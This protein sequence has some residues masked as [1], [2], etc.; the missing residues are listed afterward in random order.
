MEKREEEINGEEEI[1]AHHVWPTIT[2]QKR[3][4]ND[5]FV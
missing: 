4:T 5:F 1:N 2:I 3:C